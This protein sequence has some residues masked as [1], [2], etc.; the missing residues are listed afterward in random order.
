MGFLEDKLMKMNL[1]LAQYKNL[2]KVS[3]IS[4]DKNIEIETVVNDY[5]NTQIY[6]R[7][8]IA[9]QKTDPGLCK[10]HWK[11]ILDSV[12]TNIGPKGSLRKKV[13]DRL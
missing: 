2:L 5:K 13:S 12:G 10:E 8:Q 3:D 7:N 9:D 4:N 1:E 11:K 6:L